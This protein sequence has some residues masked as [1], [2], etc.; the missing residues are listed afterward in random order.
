[1]PDDE[2][3]D[4]FRLAEIELI[5]TTPTH[6][7]SELNAAKFALW[8]GARPSEW[9]A[10]S[11]NDI[12]F[13]NREATFTRAVVLGD[14]K[15]TKTK[16]SKRSIDLIKPALEAL[17][18]QKKLTWHLPSIKVQVLQRDNRTWREESIRPVFVNHKTLKPYTR[19]KYYESCFWKTHLEKAEVL[20]RGASL[21]RHTFASSMLTAGQDLQW[22]CD[23]LGHSNDS[24][25]RKRYGKYFKRDRAVNPADTVNKAFNF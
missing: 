6:R 17:E 1:M 21:C 9:L 25:L 7:P 5:L 23:M 11:W 12:D 22:I 14:Y 19:I 3:P 13:D 15:A 2:D 24:M 4:A 8:T 18:Q 20:Y 10:L 16:R